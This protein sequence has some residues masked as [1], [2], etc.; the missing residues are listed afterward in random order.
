MGRKKG[1]KKGQL[2]AGK[3]YKTSIP[4]INVPQMDNEAMLKK[5]SKYSKKET[6]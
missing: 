6:K 3:E 2:T 4:T 1:I 5:Q